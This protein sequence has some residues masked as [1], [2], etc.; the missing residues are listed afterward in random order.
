M[1][2]PLRYRG[3]TFY[4]SGYHPPVHR[5]R[6][7]TTLQVV[8]NRGWMIPYVACMIVVIGMVA[9]FLISV[10]RFISRREAEELA[11][12]DV[13]T[14]E[15]VESCR[16]RPRRKQAGAISRKP[17]PAAASIGR[18]LACRRSRPALFFLFVGS[19]ARARRRPSR[20]RWTSSRFGQLARRPH[21]PRQA[22]RHARPQHAAG[23]LTVNSRDRSRLRRR[24]TSSRRRSG[25]WK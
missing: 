4:Q 9:H 7:A 17:R 18:R 13:I 15:A 22:A 12:G 14:A 5:R 6:E 10:T 21:G 11:A 8:L 2:D 24:Q 3:D 23:D 16:H 19:A 20:T 25:C 1:N